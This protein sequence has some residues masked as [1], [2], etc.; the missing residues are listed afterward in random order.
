VTLVSAV[1][2]DAAPVDARADQ[3][4]ARWMIASALAVVLAVT[5]GGITRLTD[6]G[7]S[8]TEWKP[9]SRMLAQGV[10]LVLTVPFFVLLMR[11]RIRPA[12]RLRL[13]NLPLLAALQG[14]MGWDMVQSGLSGQTNVNPYRLVAH[15]AIAIV[16]FTIAVWT[17]AELSGATYP[18]RKTR[19]GRETSRPRAARIPRPRRA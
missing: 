6:S 16:I 17:A 18:A 1:H 7:L 12:M 8:I 3:A 11:R 9:V 4:V 14:G 19:T 15:L 13:M 10:G 5:V 2:E